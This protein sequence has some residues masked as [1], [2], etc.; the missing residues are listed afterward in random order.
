M[1][2]LNVI[3]APLVIKEVMLIQ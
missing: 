2:C 3:Y 1:A